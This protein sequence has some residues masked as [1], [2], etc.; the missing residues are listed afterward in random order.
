MRPLIFAHRG[1]DVGRSNS[2]EAIR[3]AAERGVAGVEIDIQLAADGRLIARHDLGPNDGG[4]SFDDLAAVLA[5]VG[6]LDIVLLIDFKSAGVDRVEA[7]GSALDQALAQVVHVDRIIVS[8]F[9]V[10]FLENVRMRRPELACYP[11][12]SLRQN[13]IGLGSLDRW[14]GISVLAAALVV[15]P[16][17]VWRTRRA[18][19]HLLVW[20]GATEWRPAISAATA[21]RAHGL[22]LHRLGSV[23]SA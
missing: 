22:I 7:E 1:G 9:S 15:N 3:S 2:V 19:R 4:E 11:I 12:I 8:S 10:P 20:F 18:N 21:L 5:V 23:H 13:F 14:E 6:E 16:L 17:L